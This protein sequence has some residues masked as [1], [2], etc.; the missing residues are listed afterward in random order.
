MANTNGRL[1]NVGTWIE[2]DVTTY[3]VATLFEG[4]QLGQIWERNGITYQIALL[5]STSSAVV[6][7]TPVM[8]SD[9]SN[10]VVSAKV[11]DAKRNF[12]AG[13]GLGTVTAGN[14]IV[15][16]VAGP[17]ALA[18]QDGLTTAAGDVLVMSATDGQLTVVTAGT[19]PTY[20]E[21][22]VATGVNVLVAAGTLAS[23]TVPLQIRV[24]LNI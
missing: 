15:I 14:Y 19:A 23:S 5:K 22:G 3:N 16:Q 20:I 17:Y 9:F 24:P 12:I 10:F 1:F 21:V 2:S 13:I 7:G 18:V 4:G 11:S 8:W 6:A